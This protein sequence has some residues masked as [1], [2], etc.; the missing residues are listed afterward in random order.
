MSKLDRQ[1]ARERIT[2]VFPKCKACRGN[3]IVSVKVGQTFETD[4]PDEHRMAYRGYPCPH[5]ADRKDLSLALAELEA[6]SALIQSMR[7]ALE[8]YACCPSEKDWVNLDPS[9]ARAALAQVSASLKEE[10]N[11]GR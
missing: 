10:Q 1:A 4:S 8:V 2:P 7:E 9:Y 5:C 3:G 11:D 6:Q